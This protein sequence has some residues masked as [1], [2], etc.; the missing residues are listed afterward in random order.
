MH[1]GNYS[2]GRQ[3]YPEEGEEAWVLN[4]LNHS[5]SIVASLGT[6]RQTTI[7]RRD[8][9]YYH[10]MIN[11]TALAFNMVADSGRS[12]DRD[13]FNY[14]AVCNDNKNTYLGLKE[15]NFFMGPTLYDS[16][17]PCSEAVCAFLIDRK[18]F[19][20]SLAILFIV[21]S[22]FVSKYSC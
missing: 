8:R 3:F 11:A 22:S 1:L 12:P 2:E 4:G 21:C 13:T 7:S 19:L 17:S 6:P 15:P 10:Y 9:G 16:T 18:T 20:I 5:A 14:W